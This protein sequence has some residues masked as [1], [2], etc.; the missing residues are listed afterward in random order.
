MAKETDIGTYQG[1]VFKNPIS[2]KICITF[3]GIKLYSLSRDC[4]I[5]LDAVKFL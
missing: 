1:T 5:E 3:D 4:A 2:H